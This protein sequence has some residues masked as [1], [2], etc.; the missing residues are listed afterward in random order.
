MNLT[1]L[2]CQCC[3][4]LFQRAAQ[5]VHGP[6]RVAALRH[7]R[8][9]H[10]LPSHLP[11]LCRREVWTRVS[12]P[13]RALYV[14]HG[15]GL[16]PGL[17]SLQMTTADGEAHSLGGW[18]KRPSQ[19]YFDT[20]RNA[21]HPRGMASPHVAAAVLEGAPQRHLPGA[22]AAAHTCSQET[23]LGS[24][25]SPCCRHHDAAAGRGVGPCMAAIDVAVIVVARSGD[26]LVIA[27]S[28]GL[29]AMVADGNEEGDVAGP[30]PGRGV[31]GSAAMV[32]PGGGREGGALAGHAQTL[33]PRGCAGR[34]TATQMGIGPCQSCSTCR[35]CGPVAPCN[36][37]GFSPCGAHPEGK[38]G[39]ESRNMK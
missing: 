1:L 38:I 19:D 10:L 27:E 18:R 34:S 2:V 31:N 32:V 11:N 9:P 23:C 39:L 6:Q 24:S 37:A 4:R 5:R 28:M 33:V 7:P 22:A 17:A 12:R 30:A 25:Q 36:L 13:R 20:V 16:G 29:G 3:Q 26:C 21:A 8:R 14:N 15:R 35:E